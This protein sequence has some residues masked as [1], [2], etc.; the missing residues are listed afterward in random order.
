[1]T[2]DG[3]KDPVIPYEHYTLGRV[4]GYH[5][6]PRRVYMRVRKYKVDEIPGIVTN[7]RDAFGAWVRRI[8]REKDEELQTFYGGETSNTLGGG[9]EV[10][11]KVE[12]IF[13]GALNDAKWAVSK[14]GKVAG[15]IR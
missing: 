3:I 8:W 1:M 10:T 5:Q 12:G 14:V 9:N 7:D 15:F 2:F 4:F 13:K 6:G 11:Y